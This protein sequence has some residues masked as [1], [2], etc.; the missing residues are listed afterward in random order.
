MTRPAAS[1]DPSP[2]VPD[3]RLLLFSDV[4]STLIRDETIDLIADEAGCGAEVAAVTE[5]AMQGE[6][7]FTA[8]LTARVGLLAGLEATALDR[9][10]ERYELTAGAAALMARLSEAGHVTGIVSGGFTFLTDRLQ[11]ELGITHAF[12]NTLEIVDGRLTGRVSGPVVDRER[13]AALL[14]E[15]AVAEQIPTERTIAVGDGAND[16]AMVVAAGLGVAFCAKPALAEVADL[17]I[18]EPDLS[19]LLPYLGL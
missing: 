13:K 17:V 10:A 15:I 1:S 18:D 8:S 5:R 7:D 4:D 11:R 19:L 16:A 9:V 6:L 12:A 14:R 2:R 3:G